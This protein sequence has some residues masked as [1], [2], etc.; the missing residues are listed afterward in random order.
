MKKLNNMLKTVHYMEIAYIQDNVLALYTPKWTKSKM[1]ININEQNTK[2]CVVIDEARIISKRR[3]FTIALRCNLN[4]FPDPNCVFLDPF[5][6]RWVLT[7]LIYWKFFYI[8]SMVKI[9]CWAL[10]RKLQN[11]LSNAFQNCYLAL[12]AWLKQLNWLI[13]LIVSK[14]F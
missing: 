3:V 13:K 1:L 10:N 11:V 12:F 4:K 6:W 9:I 14:Y 8:N 2:V 7:K 5:K